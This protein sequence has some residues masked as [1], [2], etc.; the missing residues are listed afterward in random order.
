MTEN[1]DKPPFK[2]NCEIV[3]SL[4]KSERMGIKMDRGLV[5][6]MGVTNPNDKVVEFK[7]EIRAVKK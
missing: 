6:N 1:L 3:E 7:V 4:S 5:G 2:P